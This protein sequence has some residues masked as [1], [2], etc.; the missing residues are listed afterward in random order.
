MTTPVNR[1]SRRLKA[2]KDKNRKNGL[3][4]L[5]LLAATG[6]MSSYISVFRNTA[7]FAAPTCELEYEVNAIG[8]TSEPTVNQFQ[9]LN[10]LSIAISSDLT[11]EVASNPVCVL[12]TFVD[13]GESFAGEQLTFLNSSKFIPGEVFVYGNNTTLDGQ[14]N[15]QIVYSDFPITINDV[16]F[17]NGYS[18]SGGAVFANAPVNIIDSSFTNN[19]AGGDGGAVYSTTGA[20][21]VTGSTFSTN[22]AGAAG[23]AIFTYNNSYPVT[24]TNSTFS[25][26]SSANYGGAISTSG[27]L[28]IS[29]GSVFHLNSSAEG[30]AVA[31]WSSEGA[32]ITD[33][34][35]TSNSALSQSGGAVYGY[36]V[37]ALGS[38]FEDNISSG[39]GGAIHAFSSL[40]VLLSSFDNN[41]S[42]GGGGA[43]ALYGYNPQNQSDGLL[44]AESTFTS[45]SSFVGG[46]VLVD[47]VFSKWGEFSARV[48]SSTFADNTSGIAGGAIAA[49]G[50]PEIR[51]SNFS[52]NSTGGDGGAIDAQTPLIA[53]ST[54]YSNSAG[55]GGGAVDFYQNA[56]ISFNT[57]LD[58]TAA[59]DASSIHSYEGGAIFGNIFADSNSSAAQTSVDT[60]L[61]N[62][63]DYNLSTGAEDQ[64]SWDDT[65]QTVTLSELALD[66]QL[67]GDS[68]RTFAILSSESI[69]VDFVPRE[70]QFASVITSEG[71]PY[72]QRGIAR[73]GALDAG[74][75]EFGV[76]AAASAATPFVPPFVVLDA[77]PIIT[78]AGNIVQ[79]TGANLTRVSE[80]YVNGIKV[81]ITTKAGSSISFIAPSGLTGLADVRFVGDNHEVTLKA[82]LNFTA[83][84]IAA[85][86]AK[87]VVPGFRANSVK[88]TR[89]MK[90][91]IREFVRANPEL[92][93]VTCKGFTSAPATPADLRLARQRGKATC[94][95]IQKLNPELTVKVLNGSHTNTPGQQIRRV[96]IVMQ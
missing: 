2:R 61:S 82:A 83:A 14:G 19:I 34:T 50:N 48:F 59:D 36:G 90:K 95:Y 29:E 15:V 35:F 23:G 56:T 16:N 52:N 51:D 55:N 47:A 37:S 84:A 24:V 76:A 30:G 81:Q 73:Q 57:F 9:S 93:T 25:G 71:T 77:R 38:T 85:D 87:T 45:N 7:S 74:A 60:Q 33:S 3:A 70:D 86:K 49:D 21:S 28:S 10:D 26:N 20:V 67:S 63:F 75:Y 69:A 44:V 6:L 5:S 68:P 17:D 91:A 42:S 94:D 27:R 31:S 88:L 96:R 54:F 65:N 11:S 64:M 43:I 72:D 78:Q 46:A 62:D 66:P 12:I 8:G 53:N 18:P 22:A 13:Q 92:T 80:I 79:A 89:P 58:N 4:A 1:A 41:D 39:E 32:S 40:A